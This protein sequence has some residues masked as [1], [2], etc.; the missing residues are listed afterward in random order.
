[1]KQAP[2]SCTNLIYFVRAM[3]IRPH[4]A[5]L[6]SH[7]RPHRD[8]DATMDDA[9]SPRFIGKGRQFYMLFQTHRI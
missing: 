4:K 3:I 7:P 1:M 2:N 9:T 6:V 8:L 5:N